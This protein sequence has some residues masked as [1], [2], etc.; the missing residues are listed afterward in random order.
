MRLFAAIP[1]VILAL[2]AAGCADFHN[3]VYR[4]GEEVPA[5]PFSFAL[6]DVEYAARDGRLHLR[7]RVEVANRSG[8]ANSLIRDRFTLRVGRD[9]EIPHDRSLLESV[10]LNDVRF[11]PGETDLLTIPFTLDR[12]ALDQRLC[13]IV[14]RQTDRAGRVRLSLVEAKRGGPPQ[15]PPTDA[16]RRMTSAQW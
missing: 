12:N 3:R 14:D 16:W 5:K 15:A 6:R 2:V 10:G 7:V 9:V 11:K 13:L 4:Y 8:V 1:V